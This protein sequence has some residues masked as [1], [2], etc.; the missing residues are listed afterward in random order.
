[1]RFRTEHLCTSVDVSK[2][3]RISDLWDF[4]YYQDE[5]SF[6]NPKEEFC[7]LYVLSHD[8]I[9]IVINIEDNNNIKIQDLLQFYVTVITLF[10]KM[11]CKII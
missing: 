3:L 1:M 5:I 8:H 6:E 2:S 4:D 7:T 10:A 11:I 9:Y